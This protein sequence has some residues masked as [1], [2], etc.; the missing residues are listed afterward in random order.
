MDEQALRGLPNSETTCF[1]VER[2]SV[3]GLL[4]VTGLLVQNN[5]LTQISFVLLNA[6]HNSE[7][8]YTVGLVTVCNLSKD[9]LNISC[10]SLCNH[11]RANWACLWSHW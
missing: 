6:V 1:L 3:K 4:M 11:Y 2:T 5:K 8:L 9:Q 10:V 7:P